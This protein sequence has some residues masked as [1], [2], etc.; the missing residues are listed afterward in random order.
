VRSTRPSKRRDRPARP[1]PLDPLVSSGEARLWYVSD[2]LPGIRRAPSAR[3]FR[4]RLEDGT[5]VRDLA[6]LRRVRQL[7]VPPA[8]T[9]VWSCAR[10]DGHIQTTGRDRKGRKQYRYH[11]RWRSVRNETKYSR[12]RAFGEALPRIRKQ[13]KAQLDL[14]GLS[15]DKILATIVQL[16]GGHA[17]PRGTRSTAAATTA[18]TGSR[19]CGPVTSGRGRAPPVRLPG[20]G[21]KRHEIDITGARLARIVRRCRDIPGHELLPYVDEAGA[22]QAVGSADVNASLDTLTGHKFTAKDL[23]T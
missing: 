14:P 21:G 9:D 13:V 7:A 4:N 8:W 15:R 10:A 19:H 18:R 12:L 22:R 20:K 16:P 2:D 17:D 6:T 11:T 5:A 23:R 1:I 3:G